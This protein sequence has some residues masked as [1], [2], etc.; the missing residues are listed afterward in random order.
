N[1]LIHNNW[2]DIWALPNNS[3]FANI[4]IEGITNLFKFYGEVLLMFIILG[5]YYARLIA[6]VEEISNAAIR[7][8]RHS[9]LLQQAFMVAELEILWMLPKERKKAEYFPKRISCRVRGDIYNDW[10]KQRLADN[11]W[12]RG[13]LFNAI[14][15]S[16]FYGNNED[17][18]L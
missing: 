17:S 13:I 14:S 18:S 7:R 4:A 12:C 5:V 2:T 11:E 10:V 3:T 6:Q 15:E 1:I 8:A 16:H 9:W